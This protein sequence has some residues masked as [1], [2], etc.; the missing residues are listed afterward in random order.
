MN[1]YFVFERL[2]G[3]S[4]KGLLGCFVVLL[5]DLLFVFLFEFFILFEVEC[6]L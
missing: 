3:G 2:I 4:N 6:E 1:N 5:N